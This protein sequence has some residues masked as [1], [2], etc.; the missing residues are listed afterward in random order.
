MP[1]R[2]LA[3]LKSQLNQLGPP[4]QGSI[5]LFRGQDQKYPKVLPSGLRPGA[6]REHERIWR[7]FAHKLSEDLWK[8]KPS[9][10]GFTTLDTFAYWL[11]AMAQ[12]YGAGSE[13]LDVTHD[14]EIALWFALHKVRTSESAGVFGNTAAE[15]FPFRHKVVRFEPVDTG[16][17]YVFDVPRRSNA[18]AA[19]SGNSEVKNLL[20]SIDVAEAPPPFAS[21]R[22]KAQA[23]CLLVAN[24]D[25][26]DWGRL[27]LGPIEVGRPM[28]GSSKIQL[29]T[30]DLFPAPSID[31]WYDRFLRLPNVPHF[32]KDGVV[33]RFPIPLDL[34]LQDQTDHEEFAKS[35]FALNPPL[36]FWSDSL[37]KDLTKEKVGRLWNDKKL[38]E[39]A[40]I[41]LQG[42]IAAAAPPP[43][44]GMWNHELLLSGFPERA[45]VVDLLTG[46]AVE[47]LRLDNLFFE[48]SPMESV[49][50]DQEN[51]NLVR[52]IWLVI[53]ADI[54][55]MKLFVQKFPYGGFVA[56]EML[57]VGFDPKARRFRRILDG[58]M[59]DLPSHVLRYFLAITAMLRELLDDWRVMAYPKYV[60]DDVNYLVV[61]SER[62]TAQLV[63]VPMGC[64]II[65]EKASGGPYVVPVDA[66]PVEFVVRGDA[67]F[68]DIPGRSI[69]SQFLHAVIK[70][71]RALRLPL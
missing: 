70:S 24:R 8:E 14:L 63:R 13:F 58:T 64:F 41:I 11:K 59:F 27:A 30:K 56:S 52:A 33:F 34:Y 71:G 7:V 32:E 19:Q 42:P 53:E 2:D 25:L 31:P 6:S 55:Q 62:A 51:Q 45:P 9:D 22:V 17:L 68:P 43:E 26:D 21:P 15:N 48:L 23:A 1:V 57:K 69:R 37:R 50:W 65:R 38:K 40:K 54:F 46:R 5:R 66:D 12:H 35:V 39:A 29:R 61:G 3:A 18:G 28:S 36:L 10:R 20:A 60:F 4:R 47:P 16:Y 67:P 44:S 49:G